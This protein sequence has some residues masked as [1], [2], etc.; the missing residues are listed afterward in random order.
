[1]LGAQVEIRGTVRADVPVTLHQFIQ[2]QTHQAGHGSSGGGD[3]RDDLSSDALTLK[4]Q[5]E[6][7]MLA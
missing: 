7:L 4:K 6:K 1:M 5:V 2:L 3:G